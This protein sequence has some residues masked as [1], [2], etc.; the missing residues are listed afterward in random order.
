MTKVLVEGFGWVYMVVILDWYTKTTVGFSAGIRCTAQHWL[1]ALDM[2]VNR[3]FPE[4]AQRRGL[5]FMSDIGC[6][7]TSTTFMRACAT[8]GIQQAFTSDNNPKG[9]ADPGRVIRTLKAECLQLH[10]WTCPFTLASALETWIDEYTE[11]YLQSAMGYKPR[12]HFER[13]NHSSHGTQLPAA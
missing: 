7:P 4:G 13:A 10:E 6:Q 1:L 11:H 3:R 8:V 12:R 9:T 2:A 5:S